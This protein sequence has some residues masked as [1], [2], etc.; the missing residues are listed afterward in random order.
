MESSEESSVT[1]CWSAGFYCQS[2]VSNLVK[3]IQLDTPEECQ[4]KC[5]AENQCLF[6]SFHDARGQGYCS[7]LKE[8]SG[9]TKCTSEKNCATGRK[10]CNCATLD[11][12]PGSKDSTSYARWK[13]GDVDP[14]SVTIP[15]GI[16]CS[17]TCTSSVD[18][19]LQSTCLKN[20]RWSSSALTSSTLRV[21]GYSSSYP[22]PDQPD[23]E[24]GCQ[25]VGPFNY[26]PNVEYGA[27]FVCQ[28]W[29]SDKYRTPN[30][31]TLKN[32]D[33]CQLFC[34]EGN[35]PNDYSNVVL[36]VL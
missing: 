14:Y 23:M 25:D 1:D 4:E 34:S 29:T 22:T 33:R 16:T 26:D 5:M 27:K 35:L 36:H 28:G 19:S 15:V 12:L 17:A 7:L 24:C 30:G 3:R 11:Y 13:C 20:G 6:F 18:S 8:C 10:T 21:H 32:S 2:V 9:K 31:W